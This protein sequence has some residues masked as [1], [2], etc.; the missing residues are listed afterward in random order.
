[1][2]PSICSDAMPKSAILMLFF[3]SNSRFS[4]LRSLWHIEWLWQK[5][6]AEIIC[7]KNLRASFGVRRPFLTK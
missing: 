5:S 3:S 6:R 7:R 4:G 2:D 1:M